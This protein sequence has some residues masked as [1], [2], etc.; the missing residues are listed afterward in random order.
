M[1]TH[2]DIMKDFNTRCEQDGGLTDSKDDRK[3]LL[4]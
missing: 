4:R 2:F 3:A 1:A